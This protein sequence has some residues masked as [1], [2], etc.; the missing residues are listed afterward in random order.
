M[1]DDVAV[2][3]RSIAF[4]QSGS[5]LELLLDRVEANMNSLHWLPLAGAAEGLQAWSSIAMARAT[6]LDVQQVWAFWR[7]MWILLTLAAATWFVV[8]WR[9]V[10]PGR[11]PVSPLAVFAFLGLLGGSTVQVH[12]LWSNDPVISFTAY[13]WPSVVLSLIYLG[14]VGR[15][16]TSVTAG[17][18]TVIAAV[19]AGSAAVLAYELSLGALL[20]AGASAAVALLLGWRPG[21][22]TLRL[23]SSLAA[24]VVVPGL[25]LVTGLLLRDPSDGTYTGTQLRLGGLAVKTW[26]VGLGGALPGASWPRGAAAFGPPGLSLLR[27][28]VVALAVTVLVA[29]LARWSRPAARGPRTLR[30]SPVAGWTSHRSAALVPVACLVSYWCIA[31]AVHASTPKYQDEINLTLGGVYLFYAVGFACVTLL[32]HAVFSAA[33]P[34]VGSSVALG[35]CAALAVFAVYQTAYNAQLT[36]NL[37]VGGSWSTGVLAAAAESAPKDER[38]AAYERLAT[39]PLPPLLEDF[40]TL[41]FASTTGYEQQHGEPFCSTAVNAEL[42]QGSFPAETAPDGARFWWVGEQRAVLEVTRPPGAEG[43]LV[44]TIPLGNVPC[45]TPREVGVDA[46]GSAQAVQLGTTSQSAR[47]DVRLPEGVESLEVVLLTRGPACSVTG[48]PRSFLLQV[49]NPDARPVA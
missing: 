40:R 31:T 11:A 14:L 7:V 21:R 15:L 8:S 34:R 24:V 4:M 1:A 35:A 19:L 37:Q 32:G 42:T 17:G 43:S 10:W 18:R 20:G 36:S 39:T 38:C 30:D 27:A 13:A 28:V 12:A 5:G 46:N 9:P 44:V 2:I 48:D 49:G 23:W 3:S 41:V 25:V 16:L 26:L 22:P 6:P 29:L 33:L 47:V 45:G